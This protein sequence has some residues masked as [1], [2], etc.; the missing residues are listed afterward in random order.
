MTFRTNRL[1]FSTNNDELVDLK[2]EN[3]NFPAFSRLFHNLILNILFES[4]KVDK[5]GI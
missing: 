5:F 4:I 1:Y 2:K 3:V